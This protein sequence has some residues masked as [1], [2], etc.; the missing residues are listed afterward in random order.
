MH[1]VGIWSLGLFGPFRYRC[2]YTV[3]TQ[4]RYEISRGVWLVVLV[5]VISSVLVLFILLLVRLDGSAV[6]VRRH[7]LVLGFEPRHLRPRKLFCVIRVVSWWNLNR[8]LSDAFSGHL[9]DA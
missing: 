8:R 1:P 7:C 4:L 9:P 5:A 6:P 2:S 3:Q